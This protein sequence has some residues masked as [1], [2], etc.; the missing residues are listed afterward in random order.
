MKEKEEE[1]QKLYLQFQM[2]EQ[3][4]KQLERQNNALNNH[5][6]ELVATS[7][8]LDEIKKLKANTEILVPVSTGIYAK[9][10]LK[11]NSNFIVNIGAN[12]A[13]AK[14]LDSTKRMIAEQIKE[15]SA[16]QGNVAEELQSN[17][18]K[19]ASIEEQIGQLASELQ[20]Q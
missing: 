17:M 8:S 1:L 19:A 3:Q 4:I 13:L 18:Q 11:D 7:Q 5:L 2:M 12:T 14:D 16:L 20:N 6:L 9:A 15:I 10:E